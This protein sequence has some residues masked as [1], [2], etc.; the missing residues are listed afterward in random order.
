[1]EK[2]TGACVAVITARGGSKRIPNKN[3]K[4]FCGKPILAYSILAALESGV[5][6]EV[7]VSTDN[8]KIAQT[9]VL[10]GAAVP[11]LRSAEN[12]GDYATTADVLLE[13]CDAYT[14]T[15]G[16][17]E[18]ICCI[19]PT[20]PFVTA[21]RLSQAMEL[22]RCPETESVIPVVRFGDPPQRGLLMENG[23]VRYW[24]PEYERARSQ[25]LPVV[26]HD[27]GQFYCIKTAALKKYRSLITPNCKAIVIPDTQA[28]DID[29]PDDWKLA[30]LKYKLFAKG[31]GA[32]RT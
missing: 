18:R 7:I 23:S 6:D 9:A 26:Y 2:G 19:Y 20:A 5:F 1:M 11:F 17:L 22:L 13:V 28:Q 14:H 16:P 10:Y 27:C 32:C 30:L 25:D 24:M 29:N 4:V 8:K 21:A 3:I 31:E 12:S 15:R